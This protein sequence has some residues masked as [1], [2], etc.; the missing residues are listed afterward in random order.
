V[1]SNA[2]KIRVDI[3]SCPRHSRLTISGVAVVTPASCKQ[4]QS[5]WRV[6]LTPVYSPAGFT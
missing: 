2:H 5:P 6:H 4:A 3:Q 1:T